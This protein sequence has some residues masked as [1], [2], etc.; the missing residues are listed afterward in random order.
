MIT[1]KKKNEIE[2]ELQEGVDQ[3]RFSWQHL[4][5]F[6][7]LFVSGEVC[8]LSG[9]EP[10]KKKKHRPNTRKCQWKREEDGEEELSLSGNL[11]MCFVSVVDLRRR[12]G[13][14]KRETRCSVS[15][16]SAFES[17]QR[18][19]MNDD[20]RLFTKSS[21]YRWP[22]HF[23]C[24]RLA[25]QKRKTNSMCKW[26]I[27]KKLIFSTSFHSSMIGAVVTSITHSAPSSPGLPGNGNVSLKMGGGRANVLANRRA[28][29]GLFF[30]KTHTAVGNP[31][32]TVALVSTII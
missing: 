1:E 32:I 10:K 31:Q 25:N 26:F 11:S 19:M 29:V 13:K 17:K 21:G 9:F 4:D 18:A 24:C 7:N 20:D 22:P 8:D 5:V 2:I 28:M 6:A 3:I 15:C 12:A 14:T 27:P 23:I 30:F 16:L